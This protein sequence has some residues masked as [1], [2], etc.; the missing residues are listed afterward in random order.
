MLTSYCHIRTYMHAQ[1]I[2]GDYVPNTVW[3]RGGNK[4]TVKAGIG[5]TGSVVPLSS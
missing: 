5:W 3:V 4:T 2:E 1:Q